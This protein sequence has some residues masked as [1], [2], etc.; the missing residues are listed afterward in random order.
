MFKAC[1]W[2]KCIYCTKKPNFLKNICFHLSQVCLERIHEIRLYMHFLVA[3]VG[4]EEASA[5]S[6]QKE[7][8][9]LTV[10]VAHVA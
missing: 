10:N 1:V 2:A 9:C 5:S 6:T 3:R 8:S 7:F 4:V